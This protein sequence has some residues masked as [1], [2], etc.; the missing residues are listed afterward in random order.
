[1]LLEQPEIVK[2]LP[3][4]LVALG[5]EHMVVLVIQYFLY[6]E[7]HIGK[8]TVDKLGNDYADC[9]C[10]LVLKVLGVEIRM[11]MQFLGHRQH[12]LACLALNIPGIRQRP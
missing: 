5:N 1:M 6:A 11:I 12:L 2:L 4:V 10:A 9:A 8:E 7:D 3:A